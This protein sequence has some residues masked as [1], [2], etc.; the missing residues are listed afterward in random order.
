MAQ[1]HY[2]HVLVKVAITYVYTFSNELSV[3]IK[4]KFMFTLTVTSLVRAGLCDDICATNQNA[5]QVTHLLLTSLQ[6]L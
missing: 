5:V 2:I 1:P 6:N 4:M 3:Q